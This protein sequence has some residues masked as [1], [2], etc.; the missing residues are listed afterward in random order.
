MP[1]IS[2]ERIAQILQ[3]AAEPKT[4]RKARIALVIPQRTQLAPDAPAPELGEMVAELGHEPTTKALEAWNATVSG[5]PIIDVAHS[6]G[7]S[8]ELCRKLIKEVHAAI[9]EDLKANV[10]LNR[11]LDLARIDQLLVGHLPAAKAGDTY[12]AAIVIKALQHRSKLTGQEPEPGP[13][14]QNPANVM[15]WIQNQLPQINAI[16]DS[17]PVE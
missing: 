4:K 11:Q 13:P 3:A 16:V 8:I 1:Q 9:Y 15:V 12:A 2:P 5:S 6:M 7:I 14:K 10:D 17:L